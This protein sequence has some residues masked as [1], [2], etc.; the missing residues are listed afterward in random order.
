ML[1]DEEKALVERREDQVYIDRLL[2]NED[3][4]RIEASLSI[5]KFLALQE[6]RQS[7]SKGLKQ[8]VNFSTINI[9][10]REVKEPGSEK[11]VNHPQEIE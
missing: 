7:G 10:P 6:V 1:S 4:E 3:K 5:D 8:E 11:E 9:I 2:S